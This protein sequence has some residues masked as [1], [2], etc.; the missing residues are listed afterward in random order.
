[1]ILYNWL[2]SIQ[3]FQCWQT[4]RGRQSIRLDIC[5]YHPGAFWAVL[6]VGL[7]DAVLSFLRVEGFHKVLFGENAGAAIAL[8]S[9]RL[10]CSRAADASRRFNCI[11]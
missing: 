4:S 8:P 2:L 11:T 9:A 7:T 6:I 1:M 10:V 5:L 3:G